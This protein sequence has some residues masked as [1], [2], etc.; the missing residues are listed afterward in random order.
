[1]PLASSRLG[2]WLVYRCSS[3]ILAPAQGETV[4]YVCKRIAVEA[5]ALLAPEERKIVA[6]TNTWTKSYRLPLR[7]R[8]VPRVCWFAVGTRKEVRRLLKEIHAVGKKV[9]DGYGRVREWTVEQWPDDLTWYAPGD[10]GPVLMRPLP[11]GDWL[12]RGLLG[13]R[14]DFGAVGPPYWHPSRYGEV[15]VPC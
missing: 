12:P 3:P 13:A 2:D 6:T 7:V 15:V 5:A 10:A 14:R 9:A 1:M 4:E 11:V 8:V